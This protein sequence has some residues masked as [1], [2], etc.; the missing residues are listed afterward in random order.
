MRLKLLITLTSLITL[1]SC[2]ETD[3]DNL[4]IKLEGYILQTEA[5]G[6]R[7]FTPNYF[8]T[9]ISEGRKL[10]SVEMYSSKHT[11]EFERYTD[12]SFRTTGND[13]TPSPDDLNGNYTITATSDNGEYALISLTLTYEPSDTLS[14][15]AIDS[16]TYN[17]NYINAWLKPVD[18]GY[19]YGF[20]VSPY[21]NSDMTDYYYNVATQP[22][23]NTNG[24]IQLQQHFLRSYL[25]NDHA[26]VHIY[27]SNGKNIMR[28]SES[29][30]TLNRTE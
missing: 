9:S 15:V 21:D 17:N 11:I 26:L 6:A 19:N 5:D 7:R 18:G 27:V 3:D 20:I 28:I 8:I 4:Q 22:T 25:G 13:F 10:R 1:N 14:T 29:T 30:Y 24:Q 16:I 2:T 12:Y 23:T